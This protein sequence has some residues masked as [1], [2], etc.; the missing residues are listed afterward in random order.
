MVID[1]LPDPTVS[2]VGAQIIVLATEGEPN[3]CAGD[4]GDPLTAVIAAARAAQAKHQ[5][6]YVVSV[7]NPLVPDYLQQL[8]NLGAGLAIDASPGAQLHVPADPAALAGAL[9]A[10]VDAEL[11]CDSEISGGRIV[12]SAECVG[13][14]SL[15]GA[16][17]E[18]NGADGWSLP[19]PTHIRVHGAACTALRS[20]TAVLAAD[21]PCDAVAGP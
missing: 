7:G 15:N 2:A 19:D 1:R 8:A 12:A 6:L 16:E 11:G 14:V 20:P 3:S 17:L 4:G 10:I 18:C 5:K 9:G 13:S 21:F